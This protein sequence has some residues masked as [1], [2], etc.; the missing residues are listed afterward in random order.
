[1]VNLIS[2]NSRSHSY[3]FGVVNVLDN[4]VAHLTPP[5]A[6]IAILLTVVQVQMDVIKDQLRWNLE[7]CRQNLSWQAIVERNSYSIVIQ[8]NYFSSAIYVSSRS[9]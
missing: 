8:Q 2:S 4:H 1:M 3:W 6:E 9:I 5:A 7:S